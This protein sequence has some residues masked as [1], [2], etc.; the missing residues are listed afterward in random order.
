MALGLDDK[1]LPAL[2]RR[3]CAAHDL[4]RPTA[5][6][7]ACWL[8]LLA[9]RNAIACAP[10][11]S[12][13]TLAFLLPLPELLK[14]ADAGAAGMTVTDVPAPRALILAPTREL[15]QQIAAVAEPLCGMAGL[16]VVCLGGGA[17]KEEQ[18]ARLTGTPA[19]DLVVA[20]PGRLIDLIQDGALCLARVTYFVIDEADRMLQTGSL[21]NQ[22]MEIRKLLGSKGAPPCQTLM[23]S[24]TFPPSMRAL[25]SMLV[26]EPRVELF[27]GAE[28]A[29]GASVGDLG[30]GSGVSPTVTHVV[31]VCAEHKKARKLI[32]ALQTHAKTERALVFCNR[33]KTVVYVDRFL[34][35]EGLGAA[36]LHGELAQPVREQ[37]L[38]DFRAGRNRVLVCTDVAARGLHVE[39]LDAVVLWDM[40]SRLEQ[41]VHRVGRT[42]RQG[43]SGVAVTFF[44]RNFAFMAGDLVRLLE[45]AHQKVSRESE[46][47]TPLRKT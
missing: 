20:T 16:G 38:A 19:P 31:T 8:P 43:R 30:L 25:T 7:S 12:G 37:V 47:Q 13:K 10:T 44:T 46:K 41:Y 34:R 32:K 45:G 24:A 5:V 11:G 21:K 27:D 3:Y 33:I 6:Q 29:A 35:K 36:A 17:S 14:A 4:S 9:G 1:R 40:P 39:R 42:G 15:A 26:P 28:T 2:F 23:F 22:L 18:R